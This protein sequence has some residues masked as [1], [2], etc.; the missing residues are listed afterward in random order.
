MKKTESTKLSTINVKIEEFRY[1]PDSEIILQDIDLSIS[2]QTIT[3]IYG[4]SGCGKST[5]LSILSGDLPAAESSAVLKGDLTSLKQ[6]QKLRTTQDP[7]MQIAAATVMD[8]LLLAPE[9][10]ETS[11]LNAIAKAIESTRTFKLNKLLRKNTTHLSFG[12]M[13]ILGI[14]CYWQYPPDLILLDE[15][16]TGLDCF[17]SSLLKDVIRIMTDQ[18]GSIILTH[19][20]KLP[21]ENIIHLKAHQSANAGEPPAFAV[22]ASEHS[23]S[24]ESLKWPGWS[25]ENPV[26]FTLN[27]GST[28]LLTGPNGSGKS[29][30]LIR[31]AGIL[32]FH[33]GAPDIPQS[34]SYVPQI[35]DQQI[36]A[37][38]VI[39]EALV[40]N[41]ASEA[42]ALELLAYFDMAHL[43]QLSPLLLSFGQKKRL[44]FISAILAASGCLLLDEPIAGLDPLNQQRII[45]CMQRFNDNGGIILTAT[46][47]FEVFS[48]IAS[49]R[50]HLGANN[51]CTS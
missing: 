28:T 16:F 41:Q 12:Q 21:G 36:F 39:E 13:R 38:S 44:V 50:I 4:P 34:C 24:G 51:E 1:T 15:P 27:P 29:Q 45:K 11:E 6:I 33:E 20:S 30:L 3:H 49:S 14:A 22:K 47:D 9:Y 35:P 18:G 40:G 42:S 48:P 8:E 43:A 25:T 46:H 31:L 23:I 19:T 37:A 10:I 26:S 7:Q 32:P 5:L 2:P 17:H